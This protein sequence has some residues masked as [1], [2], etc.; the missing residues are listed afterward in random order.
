MMQNTDT[1][2]VRERMACIGASLPR[3]LWRLLQAFLTWVS[4]KP[5]SGQAP[6]FRFTPVSHLIFTLLF[7]ASGIILTV[8]AFVGPPPALLLLPISLVITLCCQRKIFLTLVHATLHGTF[9]MSKK[10]SVLLADFLTLLIFAQPHRRLLIEHVRKH[11]G[12]AFCTPHDPDVQAL[13][14]FG[15]RPGMS[16]NRLW[17]TFFKTLFSPRF[18][19]LFFWT[20]F[21]SNLVDATPVRRNLFFTLLVTQV[22]L[23]SYLHVWPLFIVGWLL[24]LFPCFHMSAL[25]SFAAEHKWYRMP[26]GDMS[27][28][29]WLILQTQGR[30]VASP[31]P[32]AS[33]TS[34]RKQM[35]WVL[36]WVQLLAWHLPL[37]LAVLPCDMP[38]HDY[39]HMYVKT[40]DWANATYARQRKLE[41]GA[42]YTETWGVFSA[43]DSVFDVISTLPAPGL[44]R[45]AGSAEDLLAM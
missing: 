38:A 33:L 35:M 21:K 10:G 19:L 6:L 45:S 30:F 24:P 16:K 36:W 4:G 44:P 5:H 15:M 2:D 9:P 41:A 14:T 39:H 37:R 22:A 43:I 1:L 7:L 26:E 25:I 18:H 11:H 40:G 8:V 20:R 42:P 32:D 12:K 31:P 28:R 23:V 34:P 3:P 13:Y 17:L 29:D 27:R